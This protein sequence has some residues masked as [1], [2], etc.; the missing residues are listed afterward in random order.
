MKHIKKALLLVTI[1]IFCCSCS[2][3]NRL[4][5]ISYSNLTEKIENNETFFFVVIRDGC[6]HC[7]N[8]VP[9]VEEVLD[10]YNIVGYKLNYSELSKDEDELFYNKF[11]VDSTPT[12][13]FIKEG[14]EV[15]LLQRIEGN[16]TK[17]KFITRLKN[18]EYIK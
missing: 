11:G 9:K 3:N 12:T 18:N 13:I 6:S 7:E 4:K 2:S 8:F 17:E 1:V 14:K 16:V 10:E 15:S 5:S